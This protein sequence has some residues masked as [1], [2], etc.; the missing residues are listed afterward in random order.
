M[1]ICIWSEVCVCPMYTHVPCTHMSHV[2]TCPMYTHVPCTHMSH[3]H[4][5]PMYTHVPCTHMS[6]VHTCPMY[7][8]VPCTHMSHTHMSHVH[9]HVP[10][11]HTSHVHTCPMYT[12]V[13]C[14]HTHTHT[15]TCLYN[16]LHQP[17]VG[18]SVAKVNNGAVAIARPHIATPITDKVVVI[19]GFLVVVVLVGGSPLGYIGQQGV[20]IG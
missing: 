10:C 4:T 2:H 8:H 14:T 5:C 17:V 9:T 3:V 6:H 20:N 15:H 11:T 7:T 16:D 13:P 12:H 1:N 19:Y 18:F